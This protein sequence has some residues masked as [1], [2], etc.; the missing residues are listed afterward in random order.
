MAQQIIHV[1]R[2]RIARKGRGWC[3]TPAH[4]KDLGHEEAVRQALSRLEREGIITRLVRG[5]YEYPRQHK[6]LGALPPSPDKIA[7]AI[8]QRDNIRVQPAGAYAVNLLGLSEQVPGRVVFVTDGA[9]KKIKIGKM[10]IRL[11]RTTAKNMVMAGTGLGLI[12]QALKHIGR[13]RL[14]A[15]MKKKIRGH[16]KNVDAKTMV[17]GSQYAP[18]WIRHVLYELKKGI[19]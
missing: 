1:I 8:A 6:T 19:R 13:N 15:A 4:F 5:I 9:S 3:L 12:I 16:L 17:K 18:V 10:E 11:R 2:N 7:E 14:D